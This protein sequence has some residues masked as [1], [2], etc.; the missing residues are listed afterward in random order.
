MF[1]RNG[2]ILPIVREDLVLH[3]TVGVAEGSGSLII[4][5]KRL[6]IYPEAFFAIRLYAAF[7]NGHDGLMV[8]IPHC[9]MQ[10]RLIFEGPAYIHV[11]EVLV[12]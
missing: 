8:S 10:N 12:Y 5:I 9:Q 6:K 3:G 2:L 4:C 1:N 7:K 11:K